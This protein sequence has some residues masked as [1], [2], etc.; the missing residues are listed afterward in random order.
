MPTLRTQNVAFGAPGIPPRWT[1]GRKDA[2][3][4]AYSSASRIW[5]TIW[6]GILTEVYYPT[7]DRPQIR[8]L[9]F[10]IS[11]GE[12]FFHEEKR[13]LKPTIEAIPD[14]LGYQIT[15]ADPDGKYKIVKTI[16]ADPHLPCILIRA[17]VV[18][19]ELA[20]KLKLYVLCSP[21][22]GGNGHNNNGYVVDVSGQ[23]VLAAHQG[24]T[25]LA[26]GSSVPFSKVS[27]GYVGKSDGWQDLSNNFSM[28]WQFDCALNG[29]IALTGE[30]GA[31]ANNEFVL[32]LA[33]GHGAHSAIAT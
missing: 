1:S 30:I 32:G 13:H 18:T 14:S 21:H 3:G 25:W 2:V 6:R 16:I 31:A 20:D 29:N 9:Q 23:Q 12:T 4:T 19:E 17:K 27:C 10:L 5:Y 26:L 28:D 15:S 8:Y 22:L 11:D 24:N 7:V 33:F